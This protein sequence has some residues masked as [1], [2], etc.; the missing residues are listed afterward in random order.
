MASFLPS[1][2]SLRTCCLHNNCCLSSQPTYLHCPPVTPDSPEPALFLF[3][4]RTYHL[5]T[6]Y[7][8]STLIIMLIVCL[9]PLEYRLYWSRNFLVSFSLMGPKFLEQCLAHSGYSTVKQIHFFLPL[10][11]LLPFVLNSYNSK[12]KGFGRVFF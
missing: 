6:Y 7:I 11:P 12:L 8:I 10:F 4:Y 9:L 3:F 5:P 2:K 1:L